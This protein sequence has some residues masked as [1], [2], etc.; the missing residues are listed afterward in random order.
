M[1]FSVFI[2]GIYTGK[3]NL[4]RRDGPQGTPMILDSIT[5]LLASTLFLLV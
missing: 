5:K 3:D 1:N 4:V 2:P